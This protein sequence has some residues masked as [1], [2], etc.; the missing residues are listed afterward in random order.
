MATVHAMSDS[1]SARVSAAVTA[2]EAHTAGEIVTIVS[3]HS[4]TYADIAM[5]WSALVG[6]LALLALSLIPD[7]YLGIYDRM[8]GSWVQQWTP[9]AVFAVALLVAS[10]KFMGMWLLQLWP[11]LRLALVPSPVKHMRVRAKAVTCFKVGAERRTQGRTGVLIFLSLR[12]RRAEIVADEAIAAKVA[13][14]VWGAA[15]VA[16]LAEIRQGRIA[17]GM[18]AAVEKVGT[19]LAEHF[20]VAEGDINELPDRLIEV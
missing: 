3:A 19:V 18:I 17:D 16:M 6:L 2:A 9:R 1:D 15:M 8:T 4:D 13:P 12:E 10:L 20:P 14:E 5:L 11:P 7:F